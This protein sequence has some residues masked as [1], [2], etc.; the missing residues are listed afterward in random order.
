M[1]ERYCQKHGV[2]EIEDESTEYALEGRGSAH[3]GA[4][5]EYHV[6]RL[7]CG[8]EKVYSTGREFTH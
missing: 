4:E 8:C 3:P 6:Q 5:V 7:A 2:V 1:A